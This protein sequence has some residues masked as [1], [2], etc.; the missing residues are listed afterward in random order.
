MT[1]GTAPS[2]EGSRT[3]QVNVRLTPG[4]K[5]DVVLVAAFDRVPESTLLRTH[6]V[7]QVA[8]RAAEIRSGH[9]L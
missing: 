3:A 9:V 7:A 6:T 8:A 1:H 2:Q 5:A 4:E